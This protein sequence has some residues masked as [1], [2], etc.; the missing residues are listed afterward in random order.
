VV[1]VDDLRDRWRADRVCVGIRHDRWSDV[2]VGISE[3]SH[4]HVRRRVM[5]LYGGVP[6][7]CD[8]CHKDNDEL[9]QMPHVPGVEIGADLHEGRVYRTA[10][11]C[12]ECA[13]GMTECPDEFLDSD[14]ECSICRPI[15][16]LPRF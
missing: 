8:L 6:A 4:V 10:W 11:Y 14:G 2:S 16:D 7:S 9:T 3:V 15:D 5:N 12:D 1:G 13:E